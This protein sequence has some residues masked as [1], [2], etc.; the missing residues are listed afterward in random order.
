[1]EHDELIGQLQQRARLD[2]RGH[3]ERAVRATL[4]TLG[5]R[6]TAGAATNLAAQLPVE[7]GDHLRATAV[8]HGEEPEP[9]DSDEFLNRVSWRE[10]TDPP[11]AAFHARAA[12]EM[13]EEATSGGTLQKVRQQL[14]DDYDR[15]FEAGATGKMQ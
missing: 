8:P 12:L 11:A 7:L 5:E 1:M 4:E 13:V 2:S 15:L 6:L 10:R 3:A 9:F 14:P